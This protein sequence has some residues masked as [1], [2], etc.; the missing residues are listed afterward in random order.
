MRQKEVGAAGRG[1]G[2]EYLNK[3]MMG[4]GN[5]ENSEVTEKVSEEMEE[6]VVFNLLS[7]DQ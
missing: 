4:G 3:R 7:N 1:R 5:K 2:R 6:K